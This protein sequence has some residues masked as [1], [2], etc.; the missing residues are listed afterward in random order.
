M[1]PIVPAHL[2]QCASRQSQSL[3]SNIPHP[4]TSHNPSTGISRTLPP[5]T[6]PQQ[7][8]PA[9]SR[10]SQP[11]NRNVPH[12]LTNHSPSTGIAEVTK[13]VSRVPRSDQIG[14]AGPV[15]AGGGGGRTSFDVFPASFGEQNKAKRCPLRSTADVWA[16]MLGSRG[17]LEGV[18]GDH[19]P[20]AYA[21]R[22]RAVIHIWS[23]LVRAPP[24]RRGVT[25]CEM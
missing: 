2:E 3:N 5:I 14:I 10:Q 17:G 20:N 9:P 23:R 21:S 15:T 25:A 7:E 19:K 1:L 18:F 13:L 12:P 24:H 8:Y 4:P 22:S 6:T 11:L 16:G